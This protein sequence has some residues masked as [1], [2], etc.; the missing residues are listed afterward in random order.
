LIRFSFFSG[1]P[2]SVR[3]R[4]VNLVDEDDDDDDDEFARFEQEKLRRAFLAR[5]ARSTAAAATSVIPP[6]DEDE[7]SIPSI[8]PSSDEV[9]TIT[10]TTTIAALNVASASSTA[11]TMN[12]TGRVKIDEQS[13]LVPPRIETTT[14]LNGA[15][16]DAV[17]DNTRIPRSQTNSTSPSLLSVPHASSSTS[18]SPLPPPL[19]LSSLVNQYASN[20]SIESVQRLGNGQGQLKSVTTPLSAINTSVL[21]SSTI[22]GGGEK[23]RIKSRTGV[24]VSIVKAKKKSRSGLCRQ[25]CSW[26]VKMECE[27]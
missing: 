2:S 12:I 18:S 7:V 23:S 24:P 17:N 27:I 6:I 9:P 19:P 20:P 3:E 16:N 14:S 10:T 22:I 8:L 26:L 4:I 11:Q 15:Q 25:L 1:M 5:S 21:T 13:P